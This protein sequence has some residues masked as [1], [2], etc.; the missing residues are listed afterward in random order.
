MSIF[1]PK[2]YTVVVPMFG[3]VNVKLNSFPSLA[4]RMAA[5]PVGCG[6]GE[7]ILRYFDIL[8][9]RGA[10]KYRKNKKWIRWSGGDDLMIMMQLYI[11]IYLST[12]CLIC[13]CF[14][15]CMMN[16][17]LLL[18]FCLMFLPFPFPP[19]E[20][21]DLCFW[22]LCRIISGVPPGVDGNPGLYGKGMSYLGCRGAGNRTGGDVTR[23]CLKMM[24]STAFCWEKVRNLE[25][26]FFCK[27]V[28]LG[29]I[30]TV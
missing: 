29:W 2:S 19:D 26:L 27:Y 10:K 23:R 1:S 7:D 24:D 6:W 12:R 16:A 18:Q 3:G 11:Y 17:S 21:A 30:I 9:H 20:F 28:F 13:V 25:R 4:A 14:H 22:H 15:V 8:M 5:T